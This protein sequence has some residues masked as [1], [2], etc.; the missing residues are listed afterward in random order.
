MAALVFNTGLQRIGVNASQATGTGVTYSSARYIR[1][2]SVDDSSVAFVATDTALNTGGAVSNEYDV[3]LTSATRTSQS[4]AHLGTIPSGQ[5]NFTIRRI[6]LHDDTAAN[7][8][9]SST[10]PCVGVDGLSFVKSNTFS[11]SPTINLAY[12]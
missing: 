5:G 10:T 8:S 9:A 7:V 6:V 4:V 11:L 3:D 12:S 2:M 1:S